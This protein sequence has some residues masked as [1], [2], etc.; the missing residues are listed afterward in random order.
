MQRPISAQTWLL[1]SDRTAC[2]RSNYATTEL[3]LFGLNL[4][5]YFFVKTS[6]WLYFT[7]VV[8]FFLLSL[9]EIRSPRIFGC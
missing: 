4:Q 3:G 1:R 8:S 9:S 6:C 5:G 2:M 7:K